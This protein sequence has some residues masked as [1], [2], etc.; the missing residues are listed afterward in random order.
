MRMLLG[1]RAEASGG[2]Q[3]SA[4]ADGIMAP[5]AFALRHP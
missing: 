1:L 4:A 3:A 2:S 5:C